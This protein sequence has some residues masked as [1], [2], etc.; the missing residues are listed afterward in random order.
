MAEVLEGIR[1]RNLGLADYAAT[2]Q[3]MRAFTAR[4]APETPDE[5]WLCEH[6][7]VY[8]LGVGAD[9]SHGPGAANCIP[10]LRCERG[11][12]I[13][14][15]GPGQAVL[16]TLVDLARRGLKVKRFVWLLEEAVIELLGGRGERKAGA[17]GVYVGGAKVAALGLRVD[18]DDQDRRDHPLPRRTAA[19]RHQPEH[20]DRP[21]P[22][23]G[24]RPRRASPAVS[25]AVA[26]PLCRRRRAVTP[27]PRSGDVASAACIV[28]PAEHGDESAWLEMWRDFTAIGPEPAAPG[29]PAYVWAQV[30]DPASPMKLLIAELDG[31]NDHL[32][33]ELHRA[34]FLDEEG[35]LGSPG[36]GDRARGE[37]GN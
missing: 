13:T 19:R 17:P 12:E 18:E 10:V 6:P 21:L 15:H 23:G 36:E 30:H 25:F 3:A 22:I 14:Y 27:R 29:A 34:W 7:P 33:G 5:I 9:A 20:A 8:T 4:R 26:A 28:R 11:G 2:A 32:P 16:Y 1:L 35:L 37:A 24:D 31:A